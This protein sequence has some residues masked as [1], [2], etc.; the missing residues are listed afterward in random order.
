MWIILIVIVV[1]LVLVI[2]LI[3]RRS[4]RR[5]QEIIEEV[6]AE[7]QKSQVLEGEIISTPSMG[8]TDLSMMPGADAD[9]LQ[10]YIPPQ[11]GIAAPAE[12]PQLPAPSYEP[13]VETIEAYN[14]QIETWRTEGYNVV[15]LEQLGLTDENMFVRAFPI[16]SSNITTLKNI[17]SRINTMDTTGFE[18]QVESINL[19][20]FEPDSANAADQEMKDLEGQ[21]AL[22]RGELPGNGAVGVPGTIPE[23]QEIDAMIPQL[24]P[25]DIEQKEGEGNAGPST[26]A[27]QEAIG[28]PQPQVAE[29]VKETDVPPDVE[30]PPDLELPEPET[31]EGEPTSEQKPKPVPEEENQE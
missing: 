10:T 14:A 7:A 29:P 4:K 8:A 31:P 6:A 20:L 22:S 1:I 26:D 2:F 17:A 13:D 24:L 30:L 18:A 27:S 5:E 15:R 28:E 9:A 19:K 12:A 3:L 11:E 21:I 16:F 23:Q 25:G